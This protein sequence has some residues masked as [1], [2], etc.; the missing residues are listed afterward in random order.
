MMKLRLGERQRTPY[1]FEAISQITCAFPDAITGTGTV[2]NPHQ[3]DQAEDVGAH[4]VNSSGLTVPLLSHAVSSGIR[5]IPCISTVSELMSVMDAGLS[6]FKFL[7]AEA[8]ALKAVGGLFPDIR[9]C[10]TGGITPNNAQDYLALSNVVCVGGHGWLR[11]I[12]SGQVIIPAL[13]SWRARSPLLTDSADDFFKRYL[14][15]AFSF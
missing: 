11:Q 14:T 13:R 9:F 10:P 4:F 5:I 2:F 7:P 15:V 1:A 12:C 8:N 3:F 6:E